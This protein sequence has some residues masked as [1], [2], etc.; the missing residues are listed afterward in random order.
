MTQDAGGVVNMPSMFVR[1]SGPQKRVR[2]RAGPKR[3]PR[4]NTAVGPETSPT[5]AAASGL[6]HSSSGAQRGR[7]RK[8]PPETK[9]ALTGHQRKEIP[10]K[11]I[12][13]FKLVAAERKAEPKAQKET[14]QESDA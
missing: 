1:E 4:P 10:P 5:K 9:T 14:R 11:K 13:R 6:S 3:A 12:G 8:M 7:R 2:R